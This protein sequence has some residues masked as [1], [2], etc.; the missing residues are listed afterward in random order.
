MVRLVS[1][2]AREFSAE[3][4]R[5][6]LLRRGSGRLHRPISFMDYDLRICDKNMNWI[7]TFVKIHLIQKCYL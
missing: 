7:K 2:N 3:F 5:A 6:I 1:G 4:V